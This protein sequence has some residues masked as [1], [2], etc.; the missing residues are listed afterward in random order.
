M[1]INESE[2]SQILSGKYLTFSV[3]RERYGLGI[4]TIQEII[5]VPQLTRV[6]K[7]PDY[8][9]G[10]I[11]LRGKIIPV[12]DLRRRFG[13]EEIPYNERTCII[14]VHIRRMGSTI[15][16]GLVVDTVL[17]VIDFTEGEMEPAPEYG[18]NF[19]AS[20]ILGLGRKGDVVTIL[21]DAEL[22]LRVEHEHE[23]NEIG[24]RA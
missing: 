6:P 4:L 20:A 10:V 5:Q 22:L 1:S 3:S 23:P 16:V 24:P 7:S 21:L 13:I 15:P 18:V 12:V 19:D 14:V 11:N 2:S 17:E 8:T 9:K